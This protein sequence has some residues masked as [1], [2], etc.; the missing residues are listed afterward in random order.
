MPNEANTAR[1]AAVAGCIIVVPCYNEE[2]RLDVEA[3]AG[4]LAASDGVDF[5]MV[6][7][8]STDGT[9]EM[10]RGLC[11]RFP[12]RVD[13]LDLPRNGGKAEAV[14]RGLLHALGS[15]TSLVGFWDADLATPL[16]A[17]HSFCR[18]AQQEPRLE[19]IIGARV[20]LLGRHIQRRPLRHYLGRVFATVASLVLGLPVYDTQC[21]AK[22]FRATPRF[23]ELIAAPFRTNW[24]FDVELLA[25]LV[26]QQH[27]L[28][29]P[30][31]GSIIYELPLNE[32]RH[33][34][35]SK[36]RPGDFAKAIVELSTIYFAYLWRLPKPPEETLPLEA[37]DA[38]SPS[39]EPPLSDSP[40]TQRKA[41]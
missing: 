24:V 18:L 32:W 13:L 34:A 21:G 11:A 7:D 22:V 12:E 2:K 20:E 28:G 6:N 8:G 35:G 33:M 10:L 30:E 37:C 14:R 19:W 40:T 9:L 4:F 3:F 38:E 17:I 23:R 26:R 27:E 1:S 15:E 16:E 5:V 39:S 25:R 36:V 29:G 31:V 41:A